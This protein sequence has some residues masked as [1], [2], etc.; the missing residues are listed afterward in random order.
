VQRLRFNDFTAAQAGRA[1]ADALGRGAYPGVDRAQVYV[2]A[3]LVTLWVIYCSEFGP[4]RRSQTCAI[5]LAQMV[6]NPM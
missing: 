4:C 1:D 6:Q 2:P 3:P 5:R